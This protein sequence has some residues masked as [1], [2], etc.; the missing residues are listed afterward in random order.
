MLFS[1]E[2]MDA[3]W[4]SLL[5]KADGTIVARLVNRYLNSVPKGAEGSIELLKSSCM[6][7]SKQPISQLALPVQASH[8][9]SSGHSPPVFF[10]QFPLCPSFD[11]SLQLL[12]SAGDDQF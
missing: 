3:H 10:R 9:F 12:P 5:S 4:N 7:Q 1:T 6:V 2:L 8:K 11:R